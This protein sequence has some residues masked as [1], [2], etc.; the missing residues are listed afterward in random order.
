MIPTDMGAGGLP[1][2][3]LSVKSSGELACVCAYWHR[4]G[5]PNPFIHKNLQSKKIL[6]KYWSNPYPSR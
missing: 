5:R 3:T 2:G 1:H 6:E 4:G